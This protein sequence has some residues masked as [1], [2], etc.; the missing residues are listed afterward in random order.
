MALA[1][2]NNYTEFDPIKFKSILE[3]IKNKCSHS[4]IF[5]EPWLKSRAII[6]EKHDSLKN[7]EKMQ[8]ELID[9]YRIAY[10][11]GLAY[12]GEYLGQFILEAIVI[13]NTF[14][15]RRVKAT[16]DYHGYGYAMEIF[17]SEKQEILDFLRKVKDTDIREDIVNLHFNYNYRLRN[18]IK[19]FIF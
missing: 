6:F 9:N 4:K 14:P 17:D 5:F 7:D 8:K 2:Q 10:D 12:A 16:K 3:V 19:Y 13:N 11:K 15:L 18:W 1:Y